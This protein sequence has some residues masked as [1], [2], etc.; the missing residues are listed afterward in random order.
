[1]FQRSRVTL[2]KGLYLR[3]EAHAS[4]FGYASVDELMAFL[5]ERELRRFSGPDDM[6]EVE[7]R[8]RGLGYIE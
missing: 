8:L 7:Q 3:A 4:Q 5:L 1:M 6:S 2:D